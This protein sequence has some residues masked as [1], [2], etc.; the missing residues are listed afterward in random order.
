MRRSK[1][2]PSSQEGDPLRF[3]GSPCR[4]SIFGTYS[5][6]AYSAESEIAARNSRKSY[7]SISVDMFLAFLANPGPKIGLTFSTTNEVKVLFVN[8]ISFLCTP[9]FFSVGL[10]LIP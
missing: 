3:R 4:L 2:A 8:W 1:L 9:Q 5:L 10:R 6:K 7:L